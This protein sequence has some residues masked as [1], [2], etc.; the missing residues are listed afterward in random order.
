MIVLYYV[1][2]RVTLGRQILSS[3]SFCTYAKQ[4]TRI[5][6]SHRQHK[7]YSIDGGASNHKL[8]L[9]TKTTTTW[10]R[11]NEFDAISGFVVGATLLAYGV[12]TYVSKLQFIFISEAL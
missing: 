10:S 11:S 1:H 9:P 5:I 12:Y 4:R 3:V 7:Y 8:S 2:Y 6:L